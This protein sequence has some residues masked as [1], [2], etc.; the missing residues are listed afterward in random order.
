MPMDL[1]DYERVTRS[2]LDEAIQRIEARHDDVG[3]QLRSIAASGREIER[4]LAAL[5]AIQE[6]PKK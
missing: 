6:K 5:I 1:L 4:L 2:M 3:A